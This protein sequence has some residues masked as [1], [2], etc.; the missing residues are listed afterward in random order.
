M[1]MRKPRTP[2]VFAAYAAVFALTLDQATKAIAIAHRDSL[3][4]GVAVFSGFS[5]VL[6]RNTGVSFGMFGNTPAF[7][8]VALAL[9]ICAWLVNLA[10]RAKRKGDATAYGL[11]LGGGLGNVVDRVRL[12]GV[13]DFLD[14]YVGASHWPAFNLADTA[15][16]CGVV[17]LVVG[18]LLDRK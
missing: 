10:F 2:F 5:L 8:L 17:I 4:D 16:F 12:G 18:P 14:F 6:H 1:G 7:A 9:T 11:I 13:T 3:T 15:I